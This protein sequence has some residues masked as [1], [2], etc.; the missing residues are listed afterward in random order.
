MSIKN[1]FNIIIKVI[2]ILFIQNIIA[3]VTAMSSVFMMYTSHEKTWQMFDVL[4]VSV[5][6]LFVYLLLLWLFI[7]KTD[8]VINVLKLEKA[9]DEETLPL[10]MHR[11]TILSL[12]VIIIGGYMLING[13]PDVIRQLYDVFKHKSEFGADTYYTYLALSISKCIIGVVLIGFQRPIVN[14]IALK[15]RNHAQ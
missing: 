5:I 7:F 3:Y 1:L 4:K 8:Y 12:S 6:S 9:F 10:N 2:G 15:T 13:I 11:S 14:L